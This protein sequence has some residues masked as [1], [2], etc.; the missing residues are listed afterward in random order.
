M[1]PSGIAAIAA[2]FGISLCTIAVLANLITRL[3]QDAPNQRSLH[4]RSVPRAGGYAI[5][6]GFLPAALWFPPRFPGGFMG[7]MLPWLA[8]AWISAQDDIR[9]VGVRVRLTTHVVAGLWAAS[10]LY[11]YELWLDTDQWHGPETSHNIPMRKKQTT[12]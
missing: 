2:A 7:W 11:Y 8:V 5:W 10:W 1:S 9:G 12:E 6:A 4:V 3:P